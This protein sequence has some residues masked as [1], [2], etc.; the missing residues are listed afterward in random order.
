VHAEHGYDAL[1]GAIRQ[2]CQHSI[3]EGAADRSLWAIWL[4]LTGNALRWLIRAVN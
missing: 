4:R 1:P 3:R 2:F